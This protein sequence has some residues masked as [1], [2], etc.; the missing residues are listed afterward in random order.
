M[1]KGFFGGKLV[2]GGGTLGVVL[3]LVAAGSAAAKAP[4]PA[5]APAPASAPAPAPASAAAP[6]PAATLQTLAATAES[7]LS[8]AAPADA[9][10]CATPLLS[11]PFTAWND[12]NLYTLAPGQS[13][14]SFDGTG[15]TLLDGATIGTA[16]LYD[17]QSGPVLDLPSSA[18]AISPPMCVDSDY[19]TART[20]VRT[21][22]GAQVGVGVFYSGAKPKSQFQLSGI[23]QGSGTGFDLSSPLQVNPGTKPGW[24]MV[25]FIFGSTGTGADGQI[26]NFFVDPRMSR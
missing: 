15:W 22:G 12:S 19:P 23:M 8:G 13:L 1:T 11:T 4:A 5:P 9:T 14:D 2:L 10:A 17:G 26:Y 21:A 3:S 16:Q 18:L 24:Q 7:A 6:A 20:M 25:Q